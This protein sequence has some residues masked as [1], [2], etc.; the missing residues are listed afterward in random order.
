MK[1]PPDIA[2]IGSLPLSSLKV[3]APAAEA[4]RKSEC[5]AI[6]LQR[7]SAVAAGTQRGANFRK[8]GRKKNGHSL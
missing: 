2:N 8:P 6:F 1:I 7:L 4:A 5:A 3:A